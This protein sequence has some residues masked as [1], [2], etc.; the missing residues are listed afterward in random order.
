MPFVAARVEQRLATRTRRRG[1]PTTVEDRRETRREEPCRLNCVVVTAREDCVSLHADPR[2]ACSS[3]R[4]L[5]HTGDRCDRLLQAAN[6]PQPR[7][8][9]CQGRSPRPRRGA[10]VCRPTARFR[11]EVDSVPSRASC[12]TRTAGTG[13][14]RGE[15]SR[16]ALVLR[17]SAE[18]CLTSLNGRPGTPVALQTWG[19]PEGK[20]EHHGPSRALG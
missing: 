11:E 12:K 4:A 8:A 2:P 9:A 13:N 19:P 14:M 6:H 3:G 1:G 10:R 5:G 7:P 20:E 15:E 16:C 18:V 17:A